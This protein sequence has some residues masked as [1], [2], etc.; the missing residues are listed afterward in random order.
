[1]TK[2]LSMRVGV[3]LLAVAAVILWRHTPTGDAAQARDRSGAYNPYADN[4]GDQL[5]PGYSGPRYRLNYNYPTRPPVT[6]ADPPWRKA[7]QGKPMGKDNAVAYVQAL[8]QFIAGD[9]KTLVDDYQKWDPFAAGWYDQ[10]WIAQKIQYDLPGTTKTGNWPGREPIQGAYPGPQF[11]KTI[12]PDLKVPL[13]QDYVVVYYN[14]VAGYT[15]HRLW[16]NPNPYQPNP[17]QAQF[18]EGAIAI[19]L[20]LTTV[21]GKDWAPLE[22]SVQSNVLVPLP[23]ANPAPSTEPPRIVPVYAMQLDIIV[24]DSKTAPKTGWVYS[25]LVYDK[26]A[27]GATTWDKLVPLGAMWGNDPGV[28]NEDLRETVINPAA[29]AYARI[30]LGWGRRLSGPNDAATQSLHPPKDPTRIS[31]CMSCHGSAEYPAEAALV[32]AGPKGFFAPGS[33][34]WDQWFQDRSG[35]IPQTPGGVALDYAMVSRQ[36]LIN[37]DAAR[38]GDA[39]LARATRHLQ[40]LRQRGTY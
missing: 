12:Y 25:T 38:G 10:P 13:M 19:K 32:P 35:R 28:D 18:N 27:P 16:Q 9:V 24:K 40:L 23:A 36:A 7:L 2:R 22:G 37:W 30:T 34:Q 11:T 29:P 31:S 1:M 39:A 14:D 20:A 21:S 8:K 33:P 6:P 4:N 5:P 15:F 3:V 17:R 26:G